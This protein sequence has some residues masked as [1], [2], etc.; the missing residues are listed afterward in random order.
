MPGKAHSSSLVDELPLMPINELR[1]QLA[2]LEAGS[3]TTL[4]DEE[5]QG[6]IGSIHTG[7]TVITPQFEP[8]TLIYR[9]VR[10]V[11]KPLYKARISY[12]PLDLIRVNGRLNR[13]GE[14]MFYGSL[15]NPSSCLLECHCAE[16]G[17][18]A[19]STWKTTKP[20][21][22]QHLGYS[23]QVL[24]EVKTKRDLPNSVEHKDDTERNALIRA[25][26][27]RVFTRIVPEG[28]EH[29]YR[30]GI[31]LR[32]NAVGSMLGMPPD[33]SQCFAGIIYP[34]VSV[35]LSGDNVALLPSVVDRSM[36]LQEVMFLTVKSIVESPLEDGGK[37]TLYHL[38][39]TDFARAF[40]RD[41][42]LV[43]NG[44]STALSVSQWQIADSTVPEQELS[45]SFRAT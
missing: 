12:P 23:R 11:T 19:V 1:E 27:A 8:G 28:Q 38:R 44:D 45:S 20:I 14:A 10:V 26:Q 15:G 16:G 31:A 22:L 32:K 34:A 24:D 21:I 3:F 7:F 4:S 25:W 13:A 2:A 37:K 17:T 39:A 29:L 40:R 33:R 18:F 42:R 35:W 6:R 9:A 5:L 41:G 36:S 30:L 43:W